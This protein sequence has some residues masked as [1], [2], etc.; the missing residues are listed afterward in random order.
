MTSPLRR[1][2]IG[3][4][5]C[6]AIGLGV[7]WEASRY[8]IGTLGKMGPGFYPAA[9]GVVLTVM[10]CL[11]AA[12]ASNDEVADPLHDV[13]DT[14]QWRGRLCIVAG[15]ALFI[16][17][18]SLSGLLLAT[19]ACVLVAALGDRSASLRGSLALAAVMTG[20]GALLFRWL[21]NVN[22]PLW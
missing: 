12:T 21:L 9:L 6:V 20:F 4:G 1:D 17:L 18:N 5:L 8:S 14:P 22:L 10:G 15:V 19:F 3:G 7:L 11:I 13:P 2:R 16:V